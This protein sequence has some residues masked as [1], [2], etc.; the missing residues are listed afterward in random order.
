MLTNQIETNKNTRIEKDYRVIVETKNSPNVSY[1]TGPD[2]AGNNVDKL[3]TLP[4]GYIGN[5]VTSWLD[6]IYSWDGK[7]E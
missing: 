7:N 3:E 6:K 5:S 2:A 1:S 4:D